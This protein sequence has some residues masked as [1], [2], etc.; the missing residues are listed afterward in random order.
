MEGSAVPRR[1]WRGTGLL[2][3][4]RVWS[5]ACTA[6]TLLL[7]A[8][9]LSGEEFGRYTFYLAVFLLLEGLADFG[10][11]SAALQRG[12]SS[13]DELAATLRAGRRI[14]ALM[15][16]A[17]FAVLAA[18]AWVFGERH[19]AWI[20]LAALYPL[21]R[22]LELSSLVYQREISWRV[23]V[24]VRSGSA[25]LRL[26]LVL[27]LWSW[28][29][30]AAAAFLLA[31]ALGAA[32]GNLLL[33]LLARSRLPRAAIEALPTAA[34]WKAAL[35]LGLAGLCQ[36]LYFYVDNAFLRAWRGELE[37]GRY[38]A[39]VR[40]MSLMI[41]LSGFA[42]SAAL[43]WLARR[44]RHGDLLAAA[45]SLSLP[46]FLFAC[47]TL[48]W[49]WPWCGELLRLVFGDG[50]ESAGPSLRWLIV[51]T[52]II[53]AGSGCVTALVAAGRMRA[54]LSINACALL[55]NLLGNAWLVPGHGMAGAAAATAATE[56]L[57]SACAWL[58]LARPTVPSPARLAA[59]L[60]GPLLFTAGAW[61]SATCFGA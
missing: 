39:A 49:V 10:T 20:A 29:V 2:T 8:R 19:A 47:A 17:G 56:L 57:V 21:S 27:L 25:S 16:C 32:A 3:L 59:W 4:G 1:V 51:A 45:E 14:R 54:L 24:V 13:L 5:S 35:P 33:H 41:M 38:N 60:A 40:V 15:A 61:L 44:H 9:H 12:A 36:Q 50:F 37:L 46:L 43:P 11:S 31:H 53:Y 23:P 18:G 22:A 52:L 42:T 6:L 30:S 26:L 7:L 34:L 55:L 48:G 58:A 28:D